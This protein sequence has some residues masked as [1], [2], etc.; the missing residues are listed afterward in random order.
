[1]KLSNNISKIN[2]S[3]TLEVTSKAQTMIKAGIDVISFGA[4]EPD[5]D[6]PDY[7]KSAAIEAINNGCTKYT[8]A[9][10][11]VELKDAIINRYKNKYNIDYTRDEVVV[12]CGGKHAIYNI[13]YCML[14]PGDEVIIPAPYW[15]SYPEQVTLAFGKSV[16]VDTLEEDNYKLNPKK[17]ANAITDKTKVL[18]LNSPS[19][20]TGQ[21]YSIQ[22]LNALL[23]VIK[24]K[25]ILVI[26]DDIY[27]DL[28]YDNEKFSNI[29]N[30]DLANRSKI[31]IVN[32]VSKTYSMT[33][34]RIGYS[35]TSTSLA[36]AIKKVQGHMTSNPSTPAQWAS[37]KALN[38]NNC[39]ITE[40]L[41]EFEKRRNRIFEL[42]TKIDGLV[43]IKPIGA[44]YVFPNI[45]SY[46][47]KSYNG[48]QIKS[49]LDLSKYLLEE[50]NVAVVPGEAFGSCDNIRMSFATS[51]E[52][53]EKGVER[54]ALALSKLV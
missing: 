35:L 39:A 53:I 15:V 52:L 45:S 11:I 6:T 38:E 23:D 33:G 47:N 5:F 51:I 10:G 12:S 21:V 31:A 49:S 19:N 40:M 22:E 54:I 13:L 27:D 43:C 48:L 24:D 1:M 25:D 28:L 46:F 30:C 50:A 32:G 3:V 18:I 36:K 29:L 7:I 16:L 14:N 41:I 9:D 34:W 2:P 26:S 20:P 17:L 37:V 8:A 42:I 4:G 44:F